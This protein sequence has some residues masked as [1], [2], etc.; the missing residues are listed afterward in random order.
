[1]PSK[2][3]IARENQKALWKSKLAERMEALISQ[4]LSKEAILKDTALKQI[5]AKLR[6]TEARLKA[7]AGRE[8]KREEM[9][10]IKAEKLAAPKVDKRKKGQAAEQSHQVSKRQMKKQKKKKGAAA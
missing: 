4:G 2:S 8:T 7:I 3:R 10:R 1:M 9:A 5:R 6:E